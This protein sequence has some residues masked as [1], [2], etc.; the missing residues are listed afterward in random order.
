MQLAELNSCVTA[1][2]A[3]W[4]RKKQ[5]VHAKFIC[6]VNNRRVGTEKPSAHLSVAFKPTFT[7]SIQHRKRLGAHQPITLVLLYRAFCAATD[8]PLVSPIW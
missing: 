7:L 5:P 2:G 3:I 8:P 6:S 4:F 1:A